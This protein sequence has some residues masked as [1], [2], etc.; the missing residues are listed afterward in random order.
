M[1]KINQNY[2]KSVS[3]IADIYSA[4]MSLSNYQ[5]NN[6]NHFEKT[7]NLFKGIRIKR[8]ILI[9]FSI[10][11]SVVFLYSCGG[12]GGNSNTSPTAQGGTVAPPPPPPP[13]PPPT[14]DASSF[15]TN[16]YLNQYGLGLINSSAAYA[17]GATGQ[18]MLIGV[19]DSGLDTTHKEFSMSK[20]AS[21]SYLSYSNYTPTTD[22][23][24]HG[25][26]VAA[27]AAGL[28]DDEGVHGVAY[29]SKV[30]FVAIQLSSPPP[31]YDPIDLGDETGAGAPDYS[32]IDNFFDELFDIFKSNG[33]GVVNNSYGWS[34]NIND[35]NEV[36]LRNAFPKTI[37][38]M[39]QAGVLDYD[40][41]IF[42]WSAGNA[43]SYADQGADYSSPEVIPG[44][45]Y[46]ISELQGTTVAVVSVDENGVI[47][48][49]SN[50]CG[51]SKDYCI[52]APGESIRI[53]YVTSLYDSGIFESTEACV[54]D[55]SCYAI[56][57]GTSF[58]APHVSGGLALLY[59][60]F[61]AQLGNTEILQ[62]LFTTANKSEIYA[63]SDIY[64]QGL[65]DLGAATSA[66]GQTSIATINSLE[67]FTFPTSSTSIGFLGRIIG[68]G[69]SKNLDRRFIVIDELGAPFYRNLRSTS[70]NAL[71][72]LEQLTYRYTNPSLRV[73][74]IHREILTNTFM[75]V[76]IKTLN[77]GEN[78][79]SPSLWARDEEK[80]DY[81]ALKKYFS[82]S[83]YYFIGQG[84]NPSLFLGKDNTRRNIHN[85]FG[86]S[87]NALS[88]FLNFANDGT[89]FGGGKSISNGSSFSG[90]FFTGKHPD[91]LYFSKHN[92]TNSGLVF[93]YNKK[94]ENKDISFQTGVL[95]ESSAMLG[96]SFTGAYGSLSDALTYFSGI[97]TSFNVRDVHFQGSY[98][99]GVTNTDLKKTG[100]IKDVSNLSSSAFN[101]GLYTNRVFNEGDRFGFR[102]SQPLRL[103]KGNI[104]LSLPVRRTVYRE[105]LFDSFV[106]D[107]EPSGRQIDV[108]FIYSTPLKN[109]TI[110]SRFGVSKDQGN[111]SRKDLQPFFETTW[112]FLVF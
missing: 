71:P 66:V 25:T 94:M 87:E 41:T 79:F 99:Y 59:Q 43:G 13:P 3:A 58:A 104:S 86:R 83:S 89:F 56:G 77:F 100:L 9:L 55:N 36:Q 84:I 42:V 102:I 109:G 37:A 33:V 90:A 30:F 105:V 81:F 67:Q 64:G 63:D 11:V 74:E 76:G 96:S 26:I 23:K 44:M 1:K 31:D 68:D 82:N 91:L 5:T 92:P 57:S 111:V 52:A 49:F 20:V 78:N 22:D 95:K 29:D 72:S 27:I 62:R 28:K 40:K 69:I 46:L 39:A 38:A 32:G 17:R 47:S 97:D 35:Y 106:S 19:T 51:V 8:N 2:L 107:L 34:G 85:F 16:E 88:P 73:K 45:A 61:D 108:E 4:A 21:G 110:K 54:A 103:E 65:M 6:K 18:G 10:L 112:E 24:R 101:L 53:A 70:V 50:R 80:L 15:E 7:H 48:D 60:F 12:G 14:S 93:E 75:T 98:F